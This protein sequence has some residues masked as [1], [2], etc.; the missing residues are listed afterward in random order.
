MIAKYGAGF[1]FG[2]SPTLADCCLIPQ[3]SSAARYKV[4]M[5][6]WPAIQAVGQRSREHPAFIAALPEN[7]PDAVQA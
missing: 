1:S 3:I 4:E 7:Q 2:D 5:D 6:A